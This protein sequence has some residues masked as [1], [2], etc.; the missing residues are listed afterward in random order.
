MGSYNM[1]D[2][3]VL[4]FP[5]LVLTVLTYLRSAVYVHVGVNNA[6]CSLSSAPCTC[7]IEKWQKMKFYMCVA[8][9]FHAYTPNHPIHNTIT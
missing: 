8:Y 7:R 9:F 4:S 1:Q 6:R 5:F 2:L 3:N